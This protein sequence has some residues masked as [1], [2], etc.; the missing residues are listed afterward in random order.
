MPCSAPAQQ[1]PAAGAPNLTRIEGS[2]TESGIHYVRLTLLAPDPSAKSTAP[3]YF[4]MECTEANGRRVLSWFVSFGGIQPGAFTPP[5]H[6]E[7]GQPKPLPNPSEKLKMSFEGYTKWKPVTRVW[8]VLPSGELR[9]RN[10]GMHSPNLET[11]RAF[12]VYLNSLPEL[13]IGFESPHG[14]S[15]AEAVFPVRPLLDELNRTP[16]C[17]P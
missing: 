6:L 4:T 13:H 12:L 16:T 11:P 1:A 3:P 2:D 8:E 10:P 5:V 14:G 15:P 7:P 9:Y 17:Q